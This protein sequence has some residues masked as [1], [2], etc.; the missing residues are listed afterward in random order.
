MSVA[1]NLTIR[2]STRDFPRKLRLAMRVAG[3]VTQKDMRAR[4]KLLNPE[5]QYEPMRAYKWAQGRSAPRDPSIYDDIARLLELSISGDALRICSYEEYRRHVEARHGPG[6]PEDSETAG[7]SL[8]QSQPMPGYMA[9]SYLTLSRAWSV[10][11]AEGWLIAGAMTF[12]PVSD[13]PWTMD[14]IERLPGGELKM[15]GPV[16]RL[17]RCLHTLLV[18]PEQEMLL[19]TTYTLPPAPAP[20]LSGVMSGMSLHDPEMRPTACRIIGLRVPTEAEGLPGCTGYVAAADGAIADCLTGIGL[21][22]S[23]ADK[24]APGILAFT[25]EPG[26]EGLIQAPSSGVISLIGLMLTEVA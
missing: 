11:R 26:N 13:G 7:T 4:I 20:I 12:H 15:K 22:R 3:C 2:P 9:G 21:T 5:T 23:L 10:H 1:T 17:G 24:M 16:R 8:P 6:I 25:S 19:S 14:Y 18:N